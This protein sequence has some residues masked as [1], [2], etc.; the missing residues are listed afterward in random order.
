MSESDRSGKST[1]GRKIALLLCV[2]A[3]LVFIA[4]W[5][6]RSRLREEVAVRLAGIRAEGLP[7]SGQ[8]MSQWR[9]MPPRDENGAWIL[10]EAMAKEKPL[11][12]GITSSDV[13]AFLHRTNQWSQETKES[14]SGYVRTNESVLAKVDEGLA[15]PRFR[16]PIDYAAGPEALLPHLGKLRATGQLLALK[17][18]L[19]AESGDGD[20]C[21]E[22]ILRT[23]KLA[24]TL[25]AEPLVA[26]WLTRGIIIQTAVRA[27]QRSLNRVAL[28]DEQCRRL[29]D[30]LA[31]VVE[32]NL[33]PTVLAGERA[34]NSAVFE[35]NP[36]KIEQM[37]NPSGSS[38][39]DRNEILLQRSGFEALRATG[40]SDRDLN[41]YLETM[42]KAREVVSLPPP[43]NLALEGL[44]DD[45]KRIARKRFYLFS[46]LLLSSGREAERDASTRA[47]VASAISALAVERFRLANKRLPKDLEELTPEFL[48]VVLDDPFDGK[49]IRY[50]V[51]G[52]G[53]VLYSVDRDLKDDGGRERPA[54][55]QSMDKSTY[56]STFIVDR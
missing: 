55:A 19:E 5:V 39:Q 15:R 9:P 33:L 50:Q 32:M 48:A 13:S 45:A 46:M 35:M 40:L 51:K 27:L 54:H 6:A 41:F 17:A 31:S 11:P 25:D 12:K 3:G 22:D 28:D 2:V 34:M 49:P 43:G 21:V 44:M 1:V 52:N 10:I 29:T 26:S 8:E 38:N 47:R 16:F 24:E 4:L 42:E 7:T 56:D 14:F 37:I 30:A 36:A 20:K 18:A 53:Y 23:L